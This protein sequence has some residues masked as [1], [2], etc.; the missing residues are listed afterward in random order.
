MPRQARLVELRFF[1]GLT[2]DEAA[3]ALD[4]GAVDRGADDWRVAR[5]WLYRELEG[6]LVTANRDWERVRDAVSRRR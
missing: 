4:I 6:S 5:A 1:G 2:S 3:D